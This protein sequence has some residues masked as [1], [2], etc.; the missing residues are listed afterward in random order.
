MSATIDNRVVEMRFDNGQ[1]EKNVATSMSTLDKLKQ[2]LNLNGAAKG[3]DEINSAAKNVNL[4]GI[5]SAAETVSAKFSALQVVGVTALVKIANAAMN[6]GTR[7][8]KA[9]TIDPIFSGFQE[10][11]TQIGSIQTILAN[12]R[13]EGTNV[14]TVNKAL[15]ELNTYADK[16]IYNFTE[17]TRN[18]GTFTAAGVKLDTSVSAIKGIANL[19]AMSGSTSAQASSA[20]YQLSQALAAGKVSL[21]DWNSVVNAGMGGQVFQDALIRTSENLKTGAKEAINTAGSFRESLTKSGW[22]TTEVLTETLK[23]F[24]GAYTEADLISQGYTKKQAKEIMDL[25]KTAESAATEVKTFTQLWD[26]L[27]EAA[28]SGWGQTWRMIIGDFDEAKKMFTG[29]SDTFG[30]LINSSADARNKVVKEWKDLGGRTAL[31]DGF[32]NIFEGISSIVK[33]IG[34]AFRNIFPPITGKQ[35]LSFTEGFRDLTEK[36]KISDETA[37][38]LKRTFSGLFSVIDIVKKVASTVA[39][40]LLDLAGSEGISGLGD[41]VLDVAA[42]IGDFFTNLNKNFNTDSL[43]SMLSSVTS[44]I[45]N[46]ISTVVG[47]LPGFVDILSSIGGVVSDVAGKIWDALSKVFT[48]ITDN[49]SA[50]DIFAGLAGG[51][52]FMAAKKL[53]GIFEKIRDVIDGFFGDKGGSKLSD[54][55]EKFGSVLDS[56]GES[57]NAFTN[58]VRIGSLIGIAVAVGILAAALKTISEIDGQDVAKS[59][60]A[61]GTMMGMLGLVFRSITKSLGK[62]GSKGVVKSAVAL[63]IIAGALNILADAMVKMSG[64]SFGELVK[65]LIGVGGGLAILAFGL[66]I[67]GKTKVPISTSLAILALAESCKILADA[68]AK[69]G[70]MSWEEIGHGLV[71]MGGALAELVG[72]VSILSKVGGFGSLAGSVGLLI[73]VQALDEIA[74]ALKN[75][76]SMSWDE[77]GRGL[78][79]MGGALGEV[80]GITGALGKIAGFSSIFASGAIFITI[81]GLAKLADAFKSFGGMSW[82]EIGRGLVGMGGALAEVGTITGALG[83]L[84]G[85]SGLLGAG[86]L[87]ITIQG[88][89]DLADAFKS[90]GGMSW[91]EIGRGLVGMGG[92]LT[93]VA[94]IS[95]TLGTLAGLPSLLGSGSLLIAIQGLGDLADAFKKFGEMNWDEIGRGLTAMGGAL[96]EVALGGLLNS[97]S[98]IGAS[99]IT[100]ISSSLGVLADSVKKWSGVTVPEGLGSQLGILADGIEKFTFGGFGADAI[101]TAAGPIGVLADSVKKWTGISVPDGIGEQFGSLASAVRKF[102]FTGFGADSISTVAAPLGALADSVKKWSGV[103]I[104][105]TLSTGLGGLADGVKAFNWLFTAGW[106]LDTITGPLGALADSVKKWSGVTIPTNLGEGLTGIAKGVTSFDFLFTAGWSLDTITGPL[107]ALANSVKKWSGVSIPTNLNEGLSSIATGL[108]SFTWLFTAGWSLSTIA[109]PFGELASAIQKF[110]GIKIPENIGDQLKKIADGIKAFSGVGDISS[111]ASSIKSISSSISSLSQTNFKGISSGLSSFASSIKNLSNISSSLTNIGSSITSCIVT[112]LSKISGELTKAGTNVVTSLT[113]GIRSKTSSVTT[114]MNGVVTKAANAIKNKNALFSAAGKTIVNKFISAIKS[115]SGKVSST[116]GNMCKSAAARARG[117]AGAFRS[118]GV[119]LVNGF[120]AGIR[121]RIAAAASAAAAMASAASAAAR[122]NLK[123][124]SPSKVFYWI[125]GSVAEGF[126]NALHDDT[127]SVYKASG[128]LANQATKGFSVAI[129]SLERAAS[130][131]IDVQPTIRPVLDLS[132]VR[133]GAGAINGLFRDSSI[134]VAAN[135]NAISSTMS[136]NGQNGSIGDVVSAID[137]LRKDLGN[138]GGTTYSINGVTYDDGSNINDAVRTLVRAAKIERRV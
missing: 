127:K 125:G 24:S 38:K 18:I 77:I 57:L 44:G 117:Y 60:F 116:V 4:S 55:K 128:E 21:M 52:I 29:L 112:P 6:A 93:E 114:A 32:K 23:Q 40:A 87:L 115:Q 27:K 99:S 12:T 33:P 22:L 118:T 122:A 135:V 75:F 80:A 51:G 65:G 13:K 26:T 46:L 124:N 45:S 59:L 14:K 43:S 15:D 20:M 107:G 70:D 56:V 105:E 42:R 53:S 49:V 82:N 120:I 3:L 68:F 119:A 41:L 72:T 84:A 5:G 85:F 106:S 109:G 130:G 138:V 62:F 83:K 71:G 102:I 133:A 10:Y 8:V 88:L 129:R 101:S 63:A 97:L 137:K 48:W 86:S 94:V 91:D 47:K 39:N 100:E 11:E 30:N 121:S 132:E 64:L 7:I 103:T 36:L 50:G 17:M 2:K 58:S 79:G 136:R 54:L 37:D 31:L 90:F 108:K 113:K 76:G 89:A 61:I 126:I 66:K 28:Q 123:V 9:L 81:Q 73:A 34:E 67:I 1:F 111:A 110:N 134:G 78:A 69:F 92:A 16:T 19:A 131:D 95:G 104:P 74:D 35:L 25:S 96:G 98:F